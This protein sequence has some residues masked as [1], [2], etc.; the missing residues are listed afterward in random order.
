M[1]DQQHA[2]LATRR[3]ALVESTGVP[4][5]ATT[6]HNTARP[7]A[8]ERELRAVRGSD[9]DQRIGSATSMD[10]R[11]E[12]PRT[13]SYSDVSGVRP[14]DVDQPI[15]R[16]PDPE[17][18]L[19]LI[20]VPEPMRTL[21]AGGLRRGTIT[22]L[23]GDGYLSAALLG[24]ALAAG[25]CAAL[26]GAD[27]LG[28]EAVAAGG[29]ALDRLLL[30]DAGTRWPAALEVLCGAVDMIL[31]RTPDQV[32][33]HAAA[34]IGARLRRG[35]ARTALLVVGG[36]WPAPLRLSVKHPQWIGLE[37]EHGQL[38]GRRAAV[39]AEGAGIYG[40]PRVARLWLPAVDGTVRELGDHDALPAGSR[41][42][43]TPVDQA[44]STAA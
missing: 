9:H 33:A 34:R 13:G 14:G 36:G 10:V 1:F 38:S 23:D 35:R 43:L 25:G 21:L 29:A 28:L 40:R 15:R 18:P 30:V 4:A 3:A 42:R 12:H 11:P 5:P 27:K 19:D 41:P 44:T 22:A 17:Q 26:I 32:T 6:G 7:S 39:V 24:A 16:D 2:G 31:I 37:D 8:H 20:A